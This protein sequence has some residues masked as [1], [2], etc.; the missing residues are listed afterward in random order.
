VLTEGRI[1][2]SGDKSLAF[3]LEESGYVGL[4]ELAESVG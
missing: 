2:K 3:E 4:E 1:M